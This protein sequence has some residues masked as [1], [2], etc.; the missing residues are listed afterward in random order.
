M[1]RLLKSKPKHHH[2][3]CLL[4]LYH[5]NNIC[6]WGGGIQVLKKVLVIPEKNMNNI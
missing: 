3:M 2:Q 6:S 5:K 1:C 4:Y